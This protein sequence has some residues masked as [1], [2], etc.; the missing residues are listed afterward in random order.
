MIKREV[1]ERLMKKHLVPN[2]P[3]VYKNEYV[4]EDFSFCEK[5]R[6]IG[7]KIYAE[8]SIKLGHQ[9]TYFYTLDDYYKVVN[10]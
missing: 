3:M 6:Q 7:Y 4:S 8:P 10:K 5:A 9:G 2:L 1:I